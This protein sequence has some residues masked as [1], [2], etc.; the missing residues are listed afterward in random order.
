MKRELKTW[1]TKC[2]YCPKREIQQAFSYKL[3]PGWTVIEIHNCGATGYIDYKDMC[4]ECT[5]DANSSLPKRYR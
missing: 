4:P 3:P 1:E 5:S 2:D